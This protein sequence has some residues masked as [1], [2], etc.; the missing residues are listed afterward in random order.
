MTDLKIGNKAPDFSL[1]ATSGN[2]IKLSKLQG[3]NV[4]LYFYPKDNTPGCTLEG[5]DFSKHYNSFYKA[6]TI[7]LGI[8]KDTIKSHQSFKTTQCFPFELLA[9]EDEKVCNLYDV[10]KDKNMYGK[11]VRGIE[12]STFLIDK[13]GKIV[14]IWR[15][16]TVEGHVK[17]VLDAVKSIPKAM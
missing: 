11:T 1:P 4:V 5:N 15:K 14:N 7:I 16:V 2:K 10:I 9:D 8:S 12:R 17:E 6:E 3:S 13:T